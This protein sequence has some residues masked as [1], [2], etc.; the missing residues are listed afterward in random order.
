MRRRQ[1]DRRDTVETVL[2]IPFTGPSYGYEVASRIEERWGDF[3]RGA[4]GARSTVT[5]GGGQPK[6]T[7]HSHTN[8]ILGPSYI[9]S[10]GCLAAATLDGQGGPKP[11]C[12]LTIDI[13][14]LN[15]KPRR[16]DAWKARHSEYCLQ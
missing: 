6:K 11:L 4:R 2:W 14:R 15:S 9:A 8:S 10:C 12:G 5:F 16:N 3:G 1:Y 13:D 7:T